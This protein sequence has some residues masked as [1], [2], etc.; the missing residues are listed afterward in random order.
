MRQSTFQR[1]ARVV[2]TGSEDRHFTGLRI[3]GVTVG[4]GKRGRVL[5]PDEGSGSALVGFGN[6]V[7]NVPCAWLTQEGGP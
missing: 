6:A 2:F 3:H 7:T 1:D 4:I 5:E